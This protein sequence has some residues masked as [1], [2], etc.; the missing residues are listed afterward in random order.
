MSCHCRI[1][2]ANISQ[3][4]QITITGA[5]TI[6]GA[7]TERMRCASTNASTRWERPLRD[8]LGLLNQLLFKQA[9]AK[10]N[11]SL[12]LTCMSHYQQIATEMR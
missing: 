4:K 11:I 12:S 9:I 6:A 1:T 10:T 7:V 3:E 8:F 5:V 2:I